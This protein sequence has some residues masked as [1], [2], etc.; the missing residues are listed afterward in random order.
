MAVT[1]SEVDPVAAA[2]EVQRHRLSPLH[3]RVRERAGVCAGCLYLCGLLTSDWWCGR[4]GLSR[5]LQKVIGTPQAVS[6][7]VMQLEAAIL[8]MPHVPLI[9][10]KLYD[11]PNWPELVVKSQ[12]LLWASW[13]REAESRWRVAIA[14]VVPVRQAA[15]LRPLDIEAVTSEDVTRGT[16][17]LEPSEVRACVAA[18]GCTQPHVHVTPVHSWRTMRYRWH[19][20][21]VSWQRSC[22][23]GLTHLDSSQPHRRQRL[24]WGLSY[25][26][27]CTSTSLTITG[28]LGRSSRPRPA[29]L[30][31]GRSSSGSL[32]P[33]QR[34]TP[35]TLPRAGSGSSLC[36]KAMC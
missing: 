16:D 35:P 1:R 31:C 24:W 6:D 23:R 34:T 4:Q 36:C 5:Y 20:D 30:H 33:R 25:G 9:G 22:V 11:D 21:H 7:E 3:V 19:N 14:T 27:L 12:P 13:L 17:D 2:R 28:K 26:R 8:R 15:Y 18:R 10:H 32:T 29:L